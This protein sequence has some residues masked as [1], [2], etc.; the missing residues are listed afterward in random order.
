MRIRL[1]LG[2]SLRQVQSTLLR[3]SHHAQYDVGA[4]TTSSRWMGDEEGSAWPRLLRRP[5][6][7]IVIVH[8]CICRTS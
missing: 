3:R 6:H 8:S 7:T 5:Q 4:T 2:G 1:Q